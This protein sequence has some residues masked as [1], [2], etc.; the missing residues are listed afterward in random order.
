MPRLAVLILGASAALIIALRRTSRSQDV[1]VA[2]VK[3]G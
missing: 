2:V 1:F 3:G